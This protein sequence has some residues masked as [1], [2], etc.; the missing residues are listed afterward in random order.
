MLFY[1]SSLRSNLYIPLCVCVCFFSTLLFC[2]KVLCAPQH[3]EGSCWPPCTEVLVKNPPN[4][5]E[6]ALDA[7]KL[8]SKEEE[9]QQLALGSNGLGE[10]LLRQVLSIDSCAMQVNS[11]AENHAFFFYFYPG[12]RDTLGLCLLDQLHF[13]FYTLAFVIRWAFASW[14]S[15]LFFFWMNMGSKE[16]RPDE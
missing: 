1:F 16:L 12:L 7:Q 9:K 2:R 5:P 8:R 6:Q 15:S 4:T 3:A 14:T 11:C 13:F 10:T